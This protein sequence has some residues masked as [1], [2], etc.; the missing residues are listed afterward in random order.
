MACEESYISGWSITE[1]ML[2][3]G[4]C[5][6]KT[7][8]INIALTFLNHIKSSSLIAITI[9]FPTGYITVCSLV[10]K[11]HKTDSKQIFKINYCS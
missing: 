2:F 10:I 1:N 6:T 3:G 5:V 7:T 11:M 9:K 4:G 8:I